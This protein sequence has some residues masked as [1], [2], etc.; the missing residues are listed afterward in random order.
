MFFSLKCCKGH[1]GLLYKSS[2]FTYSPPGPSV[3][4]QLPFCDKMHLNYSVLHYILVCKDKL[5]FFRMSIKCQI[6]C[7][8]NMA[9]CLF[10]GAKKI[11]FS[12][13][14]KCVLVYVC[15]AL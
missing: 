14:G 3:F 11:P 8:P 2:C 12:C 15:G 5:I 4:L 1:F 7:V 9:I 10:S 6:V 13:P